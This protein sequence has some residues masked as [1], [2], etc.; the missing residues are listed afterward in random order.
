MSGKALLMCT[1][2]IFLFFL[3]EAEVVPPSPC[4]EQDITIEHLEGISFT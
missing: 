3:S 1:V 2:K 4:H